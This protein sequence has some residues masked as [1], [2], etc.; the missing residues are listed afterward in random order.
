MRL[1]L[2]LLF[3]LILEAVGVV[4]L[5]QGLK[6]L[7]EPVGWRIWALAAYA[8]RALANPRLIAGVAL[9]AAFF[10]CLLMLMS[11]GDISFIWPLT[12]L[13]FVLTALAAHFI[14][15][16]PVA[17]LRWAGVA[18]IVIGAGL[19]ILS[20]DHKP[21]EPSQSGPRSPAQP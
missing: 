12:S 17:P 14:L 7:G 3:G 5:K 8:G 19:V 6:E 10:G 1:V 11:R 4:F 15:R 13:G 16:E 2:I 9:E 20:E 21:K 18:L